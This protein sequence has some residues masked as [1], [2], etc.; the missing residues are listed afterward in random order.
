MITLE[1]VGVVVGGRA[2][3]I[4]DEWGSVEAVIRLDAAQFGPDAVAGMEGFS[5][6]VV[7]FW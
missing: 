7:V 2:E 5:H 4:D 3:A 6:L 1:P